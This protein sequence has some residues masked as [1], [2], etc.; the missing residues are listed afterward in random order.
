MNNREMITNILDA[1]GPSTSK[2]IANLV[3]REYDTRLSPSQIA[4]SLRPLIAKGM[5]ASSKNDKNVTVYWM[6]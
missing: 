2:E 1:Y 4:G 6:N 5:A 3:I